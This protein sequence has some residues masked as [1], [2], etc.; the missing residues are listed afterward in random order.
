M[1][2]GWSCGNVAI[3]PL[4]ADTTP[5]LA[6]GRA[7]GLNDSIGGAA[8][9]SLPLLAG[10]FVELVGLPALAGVSAA[11]MIVPLLMLLR[12]REP[13]PGRY[14]HEASPPPTTLPK[15]RAAER[16]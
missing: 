8:S 7:I 6:R 16:L 14:A 9:I 13:A 12:L 1:G 10:P 3:V 15:P 2:L 4:I 5:P 11:L